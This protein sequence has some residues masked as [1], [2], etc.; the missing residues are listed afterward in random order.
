MRLLELNLGFGTDKKVFAEITEAHSE[1]GTKRVIAKRALELIKETDKNMIDYIDKNYA[2]LL[3]SF[4]KKIYECYS[5][6]SGYEYIE[7]EPVLKRKKKAGVMINVRNAEMKISETYEMQLYKTKIEAFKDLELYIRK[8]EN[9]NWIL[10]EL[11]TGMSVV[12]S[13]STKKVLETELERISSK[14]DSIKE[15]IQEIVASC[16]HANP[17]LQNKNENPS[18]RVENNRSNK[19]MEEK[20]N[21]ET[22][23]EYYEIE[24]EDFKT[25]KGYF[26]Y[27]DIGSTFT[28]TAE[29]EET[30]D[31][32]LDSFIKYMEDNLKYDR[33]I[34]DFINVDKTDDN[35]VLTIEVFIDDKKEFKKFEKLYKKWKKS[36][37]NSNSDSNSEKK[38]NGCYWNGNGKYQNEADKI[39]KLI[40]DVGYTNNKYMNLF[41]IGSN[42]YHDFY[43]NGGGNIKYAYDEPITK[44]LIP[45]NE[46]FRI[47]LTGGAE[48]IAKKL[49]NKK[50]LENFF[51]RVI[52]IVK[53]KDLSYYIDENK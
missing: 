23:F 40:P 7:A 10:T 2:A 24:Q 3:K 48:K 6:V 18:K 12:T 53:D 49:Y 32:V 14:V 15:K 9:G 41:I 30:C 29:N 37:T 35:Y 22:K 21:I 16:G 43:N 50:T 34:A 44:Y 42:I 25:G 4:I 20:N 8:N 5:K 11:S 51:N 45:F 26:R 46:Y 38:S 13:Y 19:E 33:C 47:D 28:V 36:F 39:S 31:S 27:T 17:H 1:A 52:E